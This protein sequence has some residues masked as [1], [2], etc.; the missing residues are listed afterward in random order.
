MY[1]GLWV[2]FWRVVWVFL[3]VLGVY[4][5]RV[6]LGFGCLMGASSVFWTLG[7]I[8]APCGIRVLGLIL[9]GL[10]EFFPFVG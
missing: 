2:F 3:Q 4:W 8:G 9:V 10:F 6:L 5:V 7:A 1:F